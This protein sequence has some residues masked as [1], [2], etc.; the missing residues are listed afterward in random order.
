MKQSVLIRLAY[1]M[2]EKRVAMGQTQEEAAEDIGI[3]YSYYSK[4][5][6]AAQSPSLDVLVRICETYHI[7]LDWLLLGWT[8]CQGGILDDLQKM[9]VSQMR[10]CRDIMDKL[11]AIVKA[12]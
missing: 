3:S 11:L 10:A 1:V 8:D 2:K 9:D 4:I 6:T 12:G 7:S 5:E